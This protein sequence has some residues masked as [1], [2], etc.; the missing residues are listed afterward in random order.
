MISRSLVANLRDRTVR[1]YKKATWHG[2]ALPDFL[3]IG[4]QKG[5]TSSLHSYVQQHE[6]TVTADIKEVHYFDG[7]LHPGWNKYAEGEKLYRS[8]FPKRRKLERCDALTF[9]ASPCYMFNPLAPARMAKLVPDAALV[10]LLRNPV[11]R[12]ISHYFH[13][14]RRG[15]ETLGIM[16]ALEAEETRLATAIDTQ[17]YKDLCWINQ[18]YVARGRYAEQLERVFA[19]FERERVLVLE[20][21]DF[22]INPAPTVAH[23]FNFVGL[24]QPSNTIDY[25]PVGT[26]SNRQ[27]VS[28]DV[29]AFLA[30]AFREPDR[31]LAD[32][33]GYK[34]SWM[35]N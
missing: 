17:D 25:R 15:R 29:S 22:F 20:S 26:G 13:E 33:L 7:G 23:V 12:A 1:V 24:A 11:E 3:I 19:H 8:Y 35:K 4:C 14:R 9:E 32:L 28:N 2:R 18:S 30:D 31:K 6:L 21:A 27:K 10:V 34:M 16:G 5:G